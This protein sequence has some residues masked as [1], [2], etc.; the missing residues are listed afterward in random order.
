MARW[1]RWPTGAAFLTGAAAT[2][3]VTGTSTLLAQS[4]PEHAGFIVRLGR[5]TL[6]VEQMARSDRR[7]ES[8]MA[9]R[10]PNARRMHYVA[11]LDNLGRI[12]RLDL[13][14]RGLG[15]GD[16][17][18]MLGSIVFRAD[19]AEVTMTHGDSTE[20]HR[21]AAPR[22]T[23]PMVA[24]SQ[25]LTEQAI[26]QARRSGGDSVAFAWLPLGS[27]ELLPSFVV[28]RG[29][30][31]ADVDFFGD[32]LHT[33]TDNTGRMLGL[34]GRATT[35]KVLV[36][37][38]KDVNV[39]AWATA[40]AQAEQAAGPMGMLSPRDT[41]RAEVAG[42][43]VIIDYG[44]PRRRGRTIWGEVVPWERVWR[45]GANAATQ[46]TIDA[47]LTIGGAVVPRGSYTLW[48][49]PSPYGGV[50]I[51]NRQTGQWGTEYDV[52]QDVA[53]VPLEREDLTPPA[54]QFTIAVD[55]RDGEALLRLGWADA[56]YVVRIGSAAS[57]G[58]GGGR[59]EN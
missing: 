54:D 4:K 55:P 7:L 6:A 37:R 20:R 33:R 24:F 21:L 35:Q 13:T 40:F 12:V 23:V 17:G 57:S 9:L 28:R 42:A 44:R 53:R 14:V 19:S 59:T 46:L 38:L 45:T 1:L 41:V 56:G 48:S 18:P 2:A 25:A 10:A 31:S 36:T 8:E 51:I 50:L 52:A 22:G 47:D 15:S 3:A 11:E 26:R 32:P 30:D 39:G 58:A 16:A 34:D 27:A 43:R 49:V 5:D 29:K